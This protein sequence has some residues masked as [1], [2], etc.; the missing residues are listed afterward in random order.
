MER[1]LVPTQNS[2]RTS[3]KAC[4]LH[5]WLCVHYWHKLLT[6]YGNTYHTVANYVV[7]A[8]DKIDAYIDGRGGGCRILH[9]APVLIQLTTTCCM[10]Q[11][12][13]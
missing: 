6:T 13:N 12:G 10:S 1:D 4:T 9:A 2:V 11:N 5:L 3:D 8:I 7:T